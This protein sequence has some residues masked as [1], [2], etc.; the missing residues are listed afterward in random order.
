ME[1]ISEKELREKSDLKRAIEKRTAKGLPFAR[2]DS[3][4]F[5]RVIL[6]IK[7][8]L[9]GLDMTKRWGARFVTTARRCSTPRI[10][11]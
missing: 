8:E 2:I 4:E 11:M 7:G 6:V 3:I 5:K 9:I 1:S 10:S